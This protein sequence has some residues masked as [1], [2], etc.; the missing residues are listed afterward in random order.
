MYANKPEMAERWQ[1]ETPKGQKLPKKVKKQEKKA[2]THR[3]VRGL[4]GKAA[5]SDLMAELLLGG[6]ATMGV[7]AARGAL[8]SAG[9]ERRDVAEGMQGKDRGKLRRAYE[10]M[11]NPQGAA[12]YHQGKA[13][14]EALGGG[15]A[16]GLADKM[17][18]EYGTGSKAIRLLQ[19]V[20][21]PLSIA[22]GPI[23]ALMSAL[24][25]TMHSAS[26][27]KGLEKGD[28]PLSTGGRAGLGAL[29]TLPSMLGGPGGAISEAGMSG[30]QGSDLRRLLQENLGRSLSEGEVGKY[31]KA[32]SKQ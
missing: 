15:E 18:G 22:G 25:R 16:E 23:T 6:G 17:H 5:S 13:L 24:K 1:A 2:M 27:D 7:G 4:F 28:D 11:V 29:S 26:V 19:N 3:G 32:R 12:A 8:G 14:R 20:T 21:S 10:H 9:P 30:I 31:Q